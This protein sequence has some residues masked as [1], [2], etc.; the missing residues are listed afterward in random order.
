MKSSGFRTLERFSRHFSGER[1]IETMR[2]KWRKTIHHS[3]NVRT[4]E[5]LLLTRINKR[6]P[7][8]LSHS[9]DLCQH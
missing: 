6:H 4:C 7:L 1:L 5:E 8:F 3:P 9:A 2:Q